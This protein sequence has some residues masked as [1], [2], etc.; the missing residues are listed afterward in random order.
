MTTGATILDGS[1]LAHNGAVGLGTNII[2]NCVA[3]VPEPAT[4]TL[5]LIGGALSGLRPA[6]AA[7]AF[8]KT[9]AHLRQKRL[10]LA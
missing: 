9:F 5:V 2:T 6:I 8:P 4:M 3:S 7:R 1:A 10:I